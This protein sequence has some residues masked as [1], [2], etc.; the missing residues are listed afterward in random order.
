LPNGGENSLQGLSFEASNSCKKTRI[1]LHRGE[2]KFRSS[3]SCDFHANFPL[4]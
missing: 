2:Q 3:F 1:F 4:H